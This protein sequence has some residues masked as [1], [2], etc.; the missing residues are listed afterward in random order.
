LESVTQVNNWIN[1]KTHT[2]IP[3]VLS[4]DYDISNVA[5]LLVN[6]IYF[7]GILGT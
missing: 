2:K 4:Q 1:N 5:L 6:T 3:S 7:K